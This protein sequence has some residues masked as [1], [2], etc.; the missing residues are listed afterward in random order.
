MSRNT[1]A[2]ANPSAMLAGMLL[3]SG[4]CSKKVRCI[5]DTH[6]PNCGSHGLHQ[7]HAAVKARREGEGVQGWFHVLTRSE[8][9]LL[10]A[11]AWD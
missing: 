1:L 9:A 7:G 4:K 6:Q 11:G 5:D 10:L 8:P 3:T 2:M